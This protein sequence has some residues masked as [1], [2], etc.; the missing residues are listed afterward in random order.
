MFQK[1]I[2]AARP[3]IIMAGVVLLFLASFYIVDSISKN[4]EPEPAPDITGVSYDEATLYSLSE[5]FG[6]TG[7]VLI[8][9]DPYEEETMSLLEELIAAGGGR[10][11]IFA[12]SVSKEPIHAQKERLET[13][14]E[15]CRILFDTDGEMAIT[16]GISGVPVTYFID[17]NGMIQDAFLRGISAKTLESSFAS[18]A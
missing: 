4:K 13:L 16:Y 15:G 8:F 5:N 18:I 7:T 6:A 1:M 9:F 12:V 10:A 3:F 2:G 14:A 11:D 17:K